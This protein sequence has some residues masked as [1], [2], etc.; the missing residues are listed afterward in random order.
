MRGRLAI[1]VFALAVA[2]GSAIAAR[3][4]PVVVFEEP[5][6]TQF[7]FGLTPSKLPRT[8][9][10]PVRLSIAGSNKTR[11]GSH[12]PAL[13]AVELQLDRRF[14]FDLA[15]VP[16]CETGIHYD[17][18]PNPIERECADAAV[19]HGQVTVEVA[20]PEQPLTTASGALTVYNRGRKPGGFDLDGWAYFSAPVTGG[21]YLPVKV[22]K[23]S[24]GR[25]GWK[26]QLEAPK[27][28]GGYGSIA[29]YSMHFLKGIVAASCGGRQLQIASTSTFV[30]GT[31]RFVTGIHT[32]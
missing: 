19:A 11:D 25:Y 22:R 3:A 29:S 5:L 12:V 9:S 32:C 21:V 4:E 6:L 7:H 24:N 13:R 10:K 17:V 1:L 23:A 31:S 30:D 15:G 14:S 8:K 28:A 26:A 27:I 20:F 2:A 16:V 18:R